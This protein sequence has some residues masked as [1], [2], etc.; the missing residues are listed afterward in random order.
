MRSWRKVAV[1][2]AA[3]LSAGL[4]PAVARADRSPLDVN[5]VTEYGESETPRSAAMGGS[6]RAIA[7]GSAGPLQDPRG[8]GGGPR[9]PHRGAH[10]VPAGAPPLGPRRRHRRLDHL[11]PGRGLLHH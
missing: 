8:E 10:P 5:V 7:T 2:L 3:L 4:A 1:C 9:L 11:P 6:I